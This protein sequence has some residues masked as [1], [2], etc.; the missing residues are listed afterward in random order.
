M[1]KE[2]TTV[3][4]SILLTI[5]IGVLINLVIA[6]IP[7][8]DCQHRACDTTVHEPT[9]DEKGYTTYVCKEC[10][11]T[12]DADFVAP[13]GH[14]FTDK[15]IAP[16]CDKEGYTAHTCSTCGITDKDN[17]TRP[18][19]HSY[20]TRDV[21]P[22][23]EDQ[24]YTYYDCKN[25]DFSLMS[26][27]VS[28]KGHDLSTRVVSPTCDD[29]G[30]SLHS[31]KDCSYSYKSDF[32]EATG[33]S[34]F[35]K[36]YVRANFERT[37]Y[38]IYT[39]NDCGRKHTGDYV[40]YTDIFKGSAGEGNG[41]LAFGVDIS[42]WSYEVDFNKLKEAGVEFVILRVGFNETLDVR[43]EEY[44]A[45]AKAAGL[46]VGVYFFT[47]AENATD[48]KADAARVAKWLDGK[49]FEYPIFYDIE[50]Y[51]DYQPSTFTEEQIMEIA[52]T[53]MTEMVEYGYY[54]GLYTNNV[55]LYNL[56]NSER[57]LTLYDVWYA[58]YTTVTD[59][60]LKTYSGRYSIWQYEG[61]VEGFAD[62]A[63][64]GSC[65]L[66]YAFKNYPEIIKK[67]GFNGYDE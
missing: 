56:Y 7:P 8:E 37:G 10:Y 62:G 40:Y 24:G 5:C 27:Y 2:I 6:L 39:C 38:T 63:I 32:V 67:Y 4:L 3:I 34:S 59:D 43:F 25:C 29:Q 47:V 20:T 48:A 31:C 45:G 12:F 35:T 44:Y 1:K 52:H 23:C 16:T 28:P 9:C 49:Q 36:K 61:W 41:S 46:D 13:T 66:N 53:F 15:V 57:T 11:H 58:R 50:D 65:D 54:P 55:F 22:T 60:I 33:H 51:E 30:Y 64:S 42:K 18:T 19:G 17:Y 14:N 21:S 26:D